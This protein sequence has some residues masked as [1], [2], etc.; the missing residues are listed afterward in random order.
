M[1]LSNQKWKTIGKTE[2]DPLI[3]PIDYRY[4]SQEM[5]AVFD[6]DAKLRRMLDVEAALVESLA[7]LGKVPESVVNGVRDGAK[8]VTLDRVKEIESETKHDVMAVVKALTEMSGDAGKYIHLTATS[9]DIVDTALALQLR[10]ALKILLQKGNTLLQACLDV[11]EKYK[12]MV[13][14]GR[15]HG[16]HAVPITLG[17]KFAN[18]ADKLGEDIVRPG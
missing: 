1:I 8:K 4:G 18:Y 11:A 5:R 17:F 12:A 15:T 14:V 16:Q 6:E 10:D 2:G 3:H 7:E 9:Y 13:M